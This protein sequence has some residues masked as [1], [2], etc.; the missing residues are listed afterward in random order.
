MTDAQKKLNIIK[1]ENQGASQ[2]DIQSWLDSMKPAQT[3]EPVAQPEEP[4]PSFL[5]NAGKFL[6]GEITGMPEKNVGILGDIFQSTVGSKGVLGALQLPGKVI[7]QKGI[8][9]SVED[10]S[11]TQTSLSDST[12]ALIKKRR[13]TTDINKIDKYSKMIQDNMTQMQEIESNKE[14]LSKGEVSPKEALATT[15]R[16][17][18]TL[19]PFA[20][21]ASG[22]TA[23]QQLEKGIGLAQTGGG[24]GGALAR[25]GV[26]GAESGVQSALFGGA[27]AFGDNKKAGEIAKTAASY[28]LTGAA[29][30]MA[31]QGGAESINAIKNSLQSSA[32]RI[33]LS[34][35]RIRAGEMRPDE[36]K[37]VVQ[38]YDLYG[39]SKDVLGKVEGQLSDLNYQLNTR[40]TGNEA[41]IDLEN[42][43]DNVK[44]RMIR[45]S[46]NTVG[47][48]RAMTRTMEDAEAE[49]MGGYG[50]TV[51]IG[52]AQALKQASG[53]LG[54]WEYGRIDPEAPARGKVWDYIYQ[55]MKTQIEQTSGVPEEVNAI[56]HEMSRLMPIRDA[57]IRALPAEQKA[58]PI[59]LMDFIGALAAIHDPGSAALVAINM[60]SR[61]GKAAQMLNLGAQG[62]G[63]IQPALNPT[64]VMTPAMILNRM[65][66]KAS[67]TTPTPEMTKERYKQ[68]Y[69]KQQ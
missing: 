9:K 63:A 24:V 47:M 49:I 13:E 59:G 4:Q 57:L 23:A 7:A 14:Q 33:Q 69:T 48:N 25:I 30:G 8:Y 28:G 27:T 60:A 34:K 32:D 54:S 26:R 53:G 43:L 52:Q 21:G 2:Q 50:K 41:T 11:K 20:K 15:A 35:L 31:I 51:D 12:L 16:A 46:G 22:L 10:L 58:A 17:E 37:K 29:F 68:L 65:T 56:N 55:E 3:P 62:L 39:P 19:A 5:Q 61:S 18:L 6:K 42:A 67:E 45:E 64:Q 44:T 66:Q 38:D 36:I 1:L 40:L